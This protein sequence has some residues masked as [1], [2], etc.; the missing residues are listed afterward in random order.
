LAVSLFHG[1]PRAA[2]IAPASGYRAG[3]DRAHYRDRRILLAT[4]AETTIVAVDSPGR[5]TG[6]Q[7]GDALVVPN[8]FVTNGP[9]SLL[10]QVR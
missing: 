10:V 6:K 9:H 4:Y 2:T 1:S 3:R 5:V 8:Q 7:Y